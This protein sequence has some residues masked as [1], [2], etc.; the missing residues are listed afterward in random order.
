VQK[1]LYIGNFSSRQDPG[2]IERLVS[3]SANIVHFK[4][5]THRDINQRH[6]GFAIVELENEADAVRVNQA[7]RGKSFHK[8]NLEA[9][10]ATAQ[11]EAAAGHPRNDD[12]PS[13]AV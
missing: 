3:W 9:R 2:E 11:E 5:M 13:T 10:A 1:T 12:N 7:L 8:A 4:M 6:G